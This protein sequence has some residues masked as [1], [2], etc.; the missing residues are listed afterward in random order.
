M[1]IQKNLHKQTSKDKNS[2][3]LL[4]IQFHFI[5]V[6]YCQNTGFSFL[7]EGIF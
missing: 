4:F 3:L 6:I 5:T 7:H 2:G 1:M